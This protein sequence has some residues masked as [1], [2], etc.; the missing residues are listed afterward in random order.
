[1]KGRES[2]KWR[3]LL[4]PL[5]LTTKSSVVLVTYE[6]RL[7]RCHKWGS[8]PPTYRSC[9][10]ITR[11]AGAVL[12]YSCLGGLKCPFR[13]LFTVSISEI[14]ALTVSSKHPSL[15][16][17]LTVVLVLAGPHIWNC[18]PAN[19]ELTDPKWQGFSLRWWKITCQ[20]WRG[21]KLFLLPSNDT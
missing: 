18:N 11:R 21:K 20:C 17:L 15:A 10:R 19:A 3:K 14:R 16:L 5:S 12:L 13:I 1:M 8:R 4:N 2:S 9:E 7:W 6:W